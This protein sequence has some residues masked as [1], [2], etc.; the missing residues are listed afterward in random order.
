VTPISSTKRAGGLLASGL[1]FQ[2]RH[3]TLDLP[4]VRPR[5]DLFRDNVFGSKEITSAE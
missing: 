4:R 2:A 5:R 3:R 1:E